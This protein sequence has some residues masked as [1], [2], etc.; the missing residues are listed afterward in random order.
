MVRTYLPGDS[1]TCQASFSNA[2]G[3][4]I[5][6]TTATLKIYNSLGE[7]DATIPWE[8]LSNPT[9]GTVRYIYEIPLDSPIGNWKYR[10]EASLQ[11]TPTVSEKY[12]VL[13]E[14]ALKTYCTIYDVYRKA[15][16]TSSVVIP[17]DV[18]DHILDS[19]AEIDE[20]MGR[21]YYDQQEVIEF[22]DTVATHSDESVRNK[23]QYQIF[24]KY[25]PIQDI[26]SIQTYGINKLP[27]RTVP[28]DEYWVDDKTGVITLIKGEFPSHK[29]SV[30][31]TYTYGYPQV[32]RN[33]KHLC[34]AMTALR[35]L[36]E[37][38]GTTYDDVTSYS[39]PTGVSVGVGE[40][41]MN[42]TKAI[43]IL[44]K[45]IDDLLSRIGR[46]RSNSVVI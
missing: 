34:T 30:K 37:Q 1:I 35:I 36:A 46:H 38:V 39:L 18:I 13:V 45:E 19:Q 28:E 29:Q 27:S 41:Y 5:N 44:R 4:P 6:P 24:L 22:I 20:I 16:I 2:Q 11:N 25:R 40:P 9:R 3:Q 42:M 17:E 10:F 15:G 8:D 26:K 12:F 7:V 23:S 21:T 32:P 31:V 33:I 14:R 43:E